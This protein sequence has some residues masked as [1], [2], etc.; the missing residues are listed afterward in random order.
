MLLSC[1]TVSVLGLDLSYVTSDR[2]HVST[3]AL[4]YGPVHLNISHVFQLWTD[5]V[6]ERF[7]KRQIQ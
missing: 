1:A 7:K 6:M 2:T 4:G 5:Q 3:S